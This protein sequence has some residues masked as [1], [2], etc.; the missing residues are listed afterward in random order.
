MGTL[1]HPRP[2]GSAPSHRLGALLVYPEGNG[3]PRLPERA[4]ASAQPRNSATGG[5]CAARRLGS[6][7]DRQTSQQLRSHLGRAAAPSTSRCS[8]TG[9][10][11]SQDQIRSAGSVRLLLD[12]WF[13]GLTDS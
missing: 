11:T 10:Q 13:Q 4:T 6:S 8:W 3:L 5:L 2:H 1:G 12:Q 7:H 9:P